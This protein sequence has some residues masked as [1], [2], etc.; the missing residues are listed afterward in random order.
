MINRSTAHLL[1][2]A[3]MTMTTGLAAPALADDFV[4]NTPVATTNGGN[5]V[6]GNDSL[7]ITS[8][9]SIIAGADAVNAGGA[10][11]TILNNGQ[12]QTTGANNEGIFA[13]DD[14][15]IT[16]NGGISTV[17]SFAE[18]VDADDDNTIANN[19]TIATQGL[20]SEGITVDDRNTISNAGS[21]V[22]RGSL[23]EGIIGDDDNT[24]VNSGSLSTQSFDS[25]G[26]QVDD[27]NTVTNNGSVSTTGTGSDGVAAS[28][29][30][31]ITNS[32]TISTQGTLAEGIIVDSDNTVTNNGTVTT[33]GLNS[34]AIQISD[35][36]IL[37]NNGTITTQ[38]I[39]GEGINADDDNTITNNGTITTQGT[40]AEAIIV[41]D[42]NTVTNSGQ[43]VS[44]QSDAFDFSSNNTL[45]LLAPAF[46]GGVIDLGSNTTVN[47]TTGASH[48]I[49]WDFSTGSMVSG[50][51]NISGTVPWFYNPGTRQVATFDP[52]ALAAQ[53][54]ALASLGGDISGLI[55]N[56]GAGGSSGSS[57]H[58]PGFGGEGQAS[59]AQARLDQAFQEGTS[60]NGNSSNW[61]I[62]GFASRAS[63]DGN[64]ATLDRD[65]NNQGIVFGYDAQVAPDFTL[66]VLGGWNTTQI[67]AG[68]RFSPSQ[69]I[70]SEGYFAALYGRANAGSGF[71]DF[72]LMGGGLGHE[73][74]RFVNNNLAPLG[75]QWASASYD[76]WW[77]APQAGVGYSIA[78][79]DGWTLT[80]YAS[81]R[82][83]FQSVDGYSETESAANAI[84]QARDHAVLEARAQI[85]G[86]RQ[87]GFGS[88]GWR[89]GWQ[90]RSASGD[91]A[92]VAMIGQTVAVSDFAQDQGAAFLG[93]S[94][95]LAISNASRIEA[96]VEG[97]FGED[98]LGARGGIK[99]VA[100][101]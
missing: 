57:S 32:G 54:D 45:N 35:D 96:D 79:P 44:A 36:N 93:A 17:G 101:F 73:S 42:R 83:A 61:W 86:D 100:S 7:T 98:M 70:D 23:A 26:I 49:L 12:L 10:A 63:H 72:A 53:S 74:N 95:K 16:N 24:I 30:N 91:D 77:F 99:F 4:V 87:T 76:S 21:I 64:S 68:S 94:I 8:T 55:A 47:I 78:G 85:S 50:A 60:T 33:Q 40:S 27:R 41:D 38:G 20:D 48:S 82:W 43:V 46:I 5:N 18:G 71:V 88:V 34:E 2:G 80:P 65:V 28:G 69:D 39:G 56:R 90:W 22:T 13:G 84:V 14:N 25:E 9:G 31:V 89:A 92:T 59:A 97:T 37:V 51:P 58:L 52:T 11:N 15:T 1:L 62:S 29:N 75:Q 19:G 67:D 81:L 3:A 6:N 66:G